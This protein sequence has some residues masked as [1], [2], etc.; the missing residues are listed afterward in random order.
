MLITRPSQEEGEVDR[1]RVGVSVAP[2]TSGGCFTTD[3]EVDDA[4]RVTWVLEGG[5]GYLKFV[6]GAYDFKS[7]S[8]Q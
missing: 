5:R 4:R 3:R 7:L 2:H 1:H 8:L 6:Q